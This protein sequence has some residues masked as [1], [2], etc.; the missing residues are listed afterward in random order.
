MHRIVDNVLAA[1]QDDS[2]KANVYMNEDD[3]VD[4]L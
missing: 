2:P 4:F 1:Y 3:D